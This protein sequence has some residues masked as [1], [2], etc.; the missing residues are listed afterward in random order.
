VRLTVLTQYFPPDGG[1][2]AGRMSALTERLVQRG[3]DVHVLASTSSYP[4]GRTAPQHRAKVVVFENSGELRVTRCYTV[5]ARGSS[6]LR[7]GI[8]QFSYGVTASLAGLFLPRPD[9]MLV[10]TPP[11]TTC[12]PALTISL[13]KNTPFV[14][15]VR[16]RWPEIGRAL[17]VLTPRSA[18]Y[19]AME[20]MKRALYRR[21]GV[22]NLV[23][24]GELEALAETGV[25]RAKLVCIPNGVDVE[26]MAGVRPALPPGIGPEL[27]TVVYAGLIGR[28]QGLSTLV[29]AAAR[30]LD[31]PNLAIAI[32][33]DGPDRGD[34][35]RLIR[36]LG[37]EKIIRLFSWTDREQ[38]W[39]WLVAAD[40]SVVPLKSDHL[41]TTVP[42]KMLESMA[43]G[44]PVILCGAGDAAAL[45]SRADGGSVVPAGDD[46]ALADAVRLYMRDP[47]LLRR[48]SRSGAAYVT[49]HLSWDGIAEQWDAV[50]REAHR[51]SARQRRTA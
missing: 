15:D 26:A 35:Q 43:L 5:P 45:V 22:I 23:T 19:A 10:T 3:Y 18:T 24:E 11:L 42:S 48:Q 36:T 32:I 44:T 16:D 8:N 41:R 13:L 7:K 49:S 1:A 33:G 37:V 39:S 46:R 14:L 2:C 17:G 34:L 40:L 47:D 6:L 51:H 20:V 25:P 29:R 4:T 38:V 30:L 21:A 28:A 12:L 31:I 27:F 50:I 9:V